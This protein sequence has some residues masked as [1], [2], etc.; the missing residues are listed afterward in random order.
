MQAYEHENKVY[1][2]ARDGWRI[3]NE[4]AHPERLRNNRIDY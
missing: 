4:T 3:R 1:I 2:I